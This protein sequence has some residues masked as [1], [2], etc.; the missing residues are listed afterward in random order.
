M[1]QLN[2]I[3]DRSAKYEGKILVYGDNFKENSVKVELVVIHDSFELVYSTIFG[4]G[5]AIFLGAIISYRIYHNERQDAIKKKQNAIKKRRN[6]INNINDHIGNMNNRVD[7]IESKKWNV[8]K[9]LLE[10]KN[11][12]IEKHT[13]KFSPIGG[14]IIKWY[15]TQEEKILAEPQSK[16]TGENT[17]ILLIENPVYDARDREYAIIGNLAKKE[18]YPSN[19]IFAVGAMAISIPTSLFAKDVL[20]GD[21]LPDVLIAIGIGFSIYRAKSIAEL[22]S[23]T[24][25]R[26]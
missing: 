18:I 15:I 22:I 24:I 2:E 7:F 9:L 3:P 19:I 23:K 13:N 17:K 12:H 1:V 10:S 5:V 21:P 25:K 4:I 14:E 6:A 26:V 11:D 8:Y 16:P 20:M